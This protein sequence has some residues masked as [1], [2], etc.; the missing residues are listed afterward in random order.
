MKL[1][2]YPAISLADAREAARE[3][4]SETGKGG[5]PAAARRATGQAAEANTLSLIARQFITRYAKRRNRSWQETERI[6]E[7]YVLPEWGDRP[8]SE[9][10]RRDILDLLDGMVDRGVPVMAKQT[11]ATIRKLFYWALDRD[12]IS[13]S[14]C[15]RVP[16]PGAAAERDRVLTDEELRAVWL[17]CDPLGWPFG[18]VVRLLILTAQRRDEVATTEWGDLDLDQRLWTI[19]G[20]RTKNGQTQEVPLCAAAVSILSEVPRTSD[21]FVFSTDGRVP[22]AGFSTAKRRLDALCGVSDWVLHDLRRTTATGL[23]RLGE[24]PHVVE[25]VLNHKSGTVSGV[26]AIYNRHGYLDEKRQALD[27][28]ARRVN[29]I[30]TGEPAK[31]VTIG[32]TR[33]ARP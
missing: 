17:A 10:T 11:H 28:W 4:F 32:R 24:A 21:V 20:R 5:D 27:A 6:L 12:I 13:T 15:V 22:V 1:G 3:V 30:V 16:V 9:I 31:V 33:Q 19:P 25:K 14:P 26:A 29:A 7:R 18:A 8:I 2:G 23:A